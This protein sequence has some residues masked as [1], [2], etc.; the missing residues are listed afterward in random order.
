MVG[1]APWQAVL[2][3]PV[4]ILAGLSGSIAGLASLISYPA[5]LAVGL[6]PVSAN[7][8]NTVSLVFN[9]VG[10]VSASRPELHG[11]RAHIVRVAAAGVAGGIAGGLLLLATPSH[12]FEL[13]VPWLIGL[14]A[15]AIL[16]PRRT[17][18]HLDSG[19]VGSRAMLPAVLLIS[20]YGGYFGAAAGVLMLAV[21]LATTAAPLPRATALKNVAL[22]GANVVAAMIFV[23]FSPVD[24][25]AVVPL[26]AGFFLGGRLGPV[27]VRNSP[28]GALRSLIAA[29]GLGLAIY[30]GVSA[31]R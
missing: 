9:G 10:S 2:L 5:L 22:G 17:V 7:V 13:I 12:S 4:G 16:L 1:V 26:A 28:A 15:V 11:Q 23:F 19:H 29:G 3:V 6:A 27:V 21:F 14:G 24:W 30:L 31:Y 8:T 20:V 25:A 18:V